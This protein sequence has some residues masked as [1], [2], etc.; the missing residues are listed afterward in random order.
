MT[1]TEVARD[2]HAML[3]RVQQGIEVAIEQNHRPVA[4]IKPST[5]AG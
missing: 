3:T 4:V 1:E 2:L 5:P